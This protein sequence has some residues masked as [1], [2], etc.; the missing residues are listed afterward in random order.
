MTI[1]KGVA[2]GSVEMTPFNLVVAPDEEA[3]A[4]AIRIGATHVQLLSG[5]LLRAL[6][7]EG[8]QTRLTPGEPSLHLPCDMLSVSID[9]GDP[10]VA[11]GSLMIGSRWRPRAWL[12]TGGFLGDLNVT[13]RAH[14]NDGVL[15][16]LEF[17]PGLGVRQLLTIRWRMRRGDHLPHPLL[18]IRRAAKFDWGSD[19]RGGFARVIVDGRIHGRARRVDVVVQPDAFTLCLPTEAHR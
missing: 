3:A 9:D 10:F 8:S 19:A 1:E 14:P 2:W 5:D 6:G 7:V 15:D 18:S 17:G 4:R 13:P 16:V 12:A 11:I